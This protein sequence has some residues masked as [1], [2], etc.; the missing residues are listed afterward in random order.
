MRPG[1]V[2]SLLLLLLRVSAALAWNP[3]GH[4]VSGAIAY[5]ELKQASPKALFWVVEVLKAHPEFLDTWRAQLNQPW[6]PPE[7]RE[8]LLFMLAARWPDDLQ[9]KRLWDHPQWHFLP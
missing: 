5:A 2:V 6:V 8:L 4:M 1:P 9:G 3:A 7:E